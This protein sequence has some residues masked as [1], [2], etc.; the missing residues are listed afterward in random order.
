MGV[1]IR[2]QIRGHDAFPAQDAE[3][4][5]GM[6][7]PAVGIAAVRR[8]REKGVQVHLCAL[9]VPALEQEKGEP[10]VRA[11]RAPA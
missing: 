4:R 11:G 5:T 9:R 3:G 10:I 1:V 7:D 2:W 8:V 6:L